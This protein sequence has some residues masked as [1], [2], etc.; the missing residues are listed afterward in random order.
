MQV[1]LG[2]DAELQLAWLCWECVRFKRDRESVSSGD[3]D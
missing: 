1:S 2:Q 3:Q